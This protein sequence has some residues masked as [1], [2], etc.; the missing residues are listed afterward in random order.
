M[1][2]VVGVV[3]VIA[4]T[5]WFCLSRPGLGMI[6]AIVVAGTG[7]AG[8]VA[9]QKLNPAATKRALEVQFQIPKPKRDGASDKPP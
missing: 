5:L 9:A 7:A 6:F 2:L 4:G 3:G 8:L 1:C